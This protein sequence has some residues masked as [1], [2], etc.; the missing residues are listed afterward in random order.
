MSD[1]T[2]LFTA[3]STTHGTPLPAE[4]SRRRVR[5]STIV[6]GAILLVLAA[7]AFLINTIGLAGLGPN[8]LL[9]SVVGIGILFVA[10]GIIGAI[11]RAA[12]RR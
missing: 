8:F 11:V 10:I 3:E 5:A 4:P 2:P 6:W 7:A 1:T 9:W 12:T